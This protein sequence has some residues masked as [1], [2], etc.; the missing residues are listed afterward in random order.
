MKIEMFQSN[1]HFSY[2]LPFQSQ[3]AERSKGWI[4][5]TLPTSMPLGGAPGYSKN[6]KGYAAFP[7]RHLGLQ[8]KFHGLAEWLA[9]LYSKC[10]MDQ[11]YYS[12]KA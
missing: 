7:L 5:E 4:L 3:E 12:K 1:I 9:R 8:P 11:V 2:H 10:R 6:G